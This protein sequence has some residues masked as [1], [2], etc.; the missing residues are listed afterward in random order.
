MKKICSILLAVMLLL[1]V[2]IVAVS[3]EDSAKIT[4]S[5][6]DKDGKLAVA[7]EEITVTDKDN[8][9]ALTINDALIS[10]HDAFYEGGAAAG[11][12]TMTTQYGLGIAKLWGS[13]NGGSYG[14]YLNNASAWSLADP[15]K[16]GDY[17][18]AFVYT[19]LTAWSD[20]YSWFDAVTADAKAGKEISL[21][22][23][24]AGYDADW[25]PVT[26][27]V[28]GASITVDGEKI[29]VTT[30]AQGEATFALSDAGEHIISAESVSMRLVPPVC[31]VNVTN[32]ADITVS[33][34]DKDGK[35]VVAAETVTVTDQD[36]D[37]ALTVND[38]LIAAHD[39]FYEGGAAAGY[40]T[41]T[42]QYGLGI[43]KLWGTANGGSYGYYVNNA[44]AWS[45]A[46]PIKDGD[47]L[48]AFVYTDPVTWSDQYSYFDAATADA[49]A[50]D[51]L[52]LTLSAAG[53]DADWNP[54]TLKV[55]GAEITVDGEKTG[56]TTDSEGK[57]TVT[58][59]DLGSHVIS[60]TSD[61]MRL[62]P[63]ACRVDVY[64]RG[65][66]DKD[67]SVSIMDATRIQR[68]LADLV[69]EDKLALSAADADLDQSVTIM[70]ATRIQRFL[71]QLCDM[72]GNAV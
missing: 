46:D 14:Y 10:A 26:L 53:Y 65:D 51:Q 9:S 43:A 29:N 59:P 32:A 58:L 36:G 30:D 67:G 24:A 8:D 25:N 40:E 27:T 1:S 57:A 39:A 71:A 35:L 60:V 61:T 4:V 5:I 17:L 48:T 62:V 50:G 69:G 70:D 44:S 6:S 20:Q 7:A 19:D 49:K 56:V 33:I 18:A 16:N 13:A 21:T 55:E 3:A 15:I 38:A 64:E 63:P 72:D 37:S 22:L 2:C 42:T 41:M 34:S 31:R 28:S 52:T 54:V 12:E 68:Y 45:L 11:Y 23:S 47:A 66:A